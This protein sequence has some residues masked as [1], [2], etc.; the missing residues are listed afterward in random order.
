MTAADV[1]R[2]MS[3]ASQ[4]PSIPG[5][6]WSDWADTAFLAI[7]TCMIIY[8]WGAAAWWLALQVLRWIW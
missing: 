2:G 7:C 1:G 3:P 4:A 5:R 6:I 8:A